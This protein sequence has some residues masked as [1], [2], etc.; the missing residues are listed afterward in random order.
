MESSP[1]RCCRPVESCA[2]APRLPRAAEL[3][4]R[5]HGIRSS[6]FFLAVSV[7]TQTMWLFERSRRQPLD[8]LFPRY[9]PR[10]RFV[11]STSRF[12][13]GQQ[14][15]SNHTPLGLH[16]IAEKVGGGHPIGTIFKS[17]RPVGFTW[18]GRPDG[19]IV[20]RILWLEGL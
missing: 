6:R 13:V 7:D 15:H 9:E 5:R 16:Q 19:M 4:A 12:G 18:R 11:V 14:M 10:R 8:A 2:R 20:H 17:R 3:A 1:E